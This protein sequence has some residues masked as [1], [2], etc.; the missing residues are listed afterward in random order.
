MTLVKVGEL[1]NNFSRYLQRVRQGGE[2]VI[3]DRQTPIGRVIP[4]KKKEE[5]DLIEP[6]KGYKGLAHLLFSPIEC[7]QDPVDFL[8]MDRH[9]R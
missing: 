5:F 8:I 9:R 6:V 7:K 2:I 1:R 4:Y 3:T